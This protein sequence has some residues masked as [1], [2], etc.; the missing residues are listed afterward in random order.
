MIALTA[1]TVGLVST[2]STQVNWFEVVP[3]VAK[4]CPSVPTPV[5]SVKVYVAPA[6]WAGLAICTAWVFCSQF[7]VNLPAAL[8]PSP[9]ISNPGVNSVLALVTA[10][11]ANFPVETFKSLTFAV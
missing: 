10:S 3:S 11:A 1:V 6:E 4:T 9:L 7:K 2:A 5:G 8:A